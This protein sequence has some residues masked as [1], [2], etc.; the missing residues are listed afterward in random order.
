MN[1]WPASQ[2]LSESTQPYFQGGLVYGALQSV[3]QESRY[4]HVA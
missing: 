1:V 2:N 4:A 3:S